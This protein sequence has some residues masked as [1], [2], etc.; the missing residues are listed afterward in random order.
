MILW[1]YHIPSLTALE[2]Y[3]KIDSCSLST[4]IAI[5]LIVS[6]NT[7]TT[8]INEVPEKA[9]FASNNPETIIGIVQIIAKK[10]TPIKIKGFDMFNK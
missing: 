10:M 4:K 3:P 9:I 1:L 6:V 8:I 2:N 5:C 7:D